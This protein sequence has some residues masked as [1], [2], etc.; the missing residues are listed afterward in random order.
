MAPP[1][2]GTPRLRTTRK[3]TAYPSWVHPDYAYWF[4]EWLMIRDVCEGEKAVKEGGKDYLPMLEGMDEDEYNTYKARAT[5]Y[6]FTGRTA[7]AMTGS[8]FR[9][10]AQMEGLT[11]RLKDKLTNI[12]MDG[13]DFTTF[14]MEVAEE[15]IKL[16]RVGVLLDLPEGATT[17]PNPYM[18]LY[19]AEDILDWDVALIKGRLALT[20]VVLNEEVLVR[21]AG[22]VIPTFVSR[23]RVLTLDAGVYTQ[24]VY[25]SAD[26]TKTVEVTITDGFLKKTVTPRVRGRTLDY[27]PFHIFGAM[28]STVDVEK[29][30]MFDIGR[31]NVSHYMSYA[32]LEH[33]RF[34]TGFPIYHVE[35]PMGVGEQEAEFLI[36]SAKVW[37]TPAGSKPGI[38]EM[39]GQGLKF[40]VD[41]LD[42]KEQQA[43]SLGGR[44]M[45]IRGQAVSESDNQL[46]I[47]ER[48][49]QSVLLKITKSLDFGFTKLLRWWA[50]MVDVSAEEAK[51]IAIEFNKDFLF[52]GVGAREF[53]AVH[54]MYKDGVIPIDIVYHYLR[55]SAVIPDWMSLKEFKGLLDKMDSFPNNAD[56]EAKK[57]G[58]ADAKSR[59]ADDILD[60][61]QEF[62]DTQ[63]EAA[64]KSAEKIA[65]EKPPTPAFGGGGKPPVK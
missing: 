63:A 53:R 61:E 56:L 34:F 22:N 58:Y 38:L 13:R 45:G 14:S 9:R 40:L 5:F 59:D 49:E 6:N 26:P 65:K 8:I 54:A 1:S 15:N 11:D 41:A 44:M 48:N 37:V 21:D 24:K 43:A 42:I 31:L 36:G 2:I 4:P 7:S 55:K 27:I 50:T 33:G 20:K 3:M 35:S 57:E 30:T 32:H 17:E 18:T 46:K 16:G 25:E 51:K 23:Y 10:Q 64:R 29:P 52:D 62:E 12:T 39:N 60:K 19:K 28:L 47:S